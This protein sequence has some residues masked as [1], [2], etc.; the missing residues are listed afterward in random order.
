MVAPVLAAGM[1]AAPIIGG[2]M[3]QQTAREARA[4]AEAQQRKVEEALA[5]V[6]DPN[7]DMSQF[8]PEEYKLVGQYAPQMLPM[9]EERAPQ[10]AQLSGAGQQG[11]QAM[12]GALQHLTNLG[13]T[14]ADA[15]S[16]ALN[17]QA[18]QQAA[19]QN[20]GQQASIL[21]SMQRRG[22]G[23]GSGLGFAA[24][25]SAQQ[26][27]GQQASQAGTQQA[28][29]NYQNRLQALMQA[30]Q[31]GGQ[32]QNM[33]FN[34]QQTNAGIINQFNQ[35]MANAQQQNAMYN[36]G[37]LNEARRT[38]LGAQQNTADQNVAM[39]NQALAQKNQLA[40][41][42]YQNALDKVRVQAGV[43]NQ[44]AQNALAS[45]AQQNQATQGLTQ[46]ISS[47]LMFAGSGNDSKQT[48]DGLYVDPLEQKNY[49]FRNPS[50]RNV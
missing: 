8:S 21:D 38:N 49:N 12:L 31:M 4:A 20:Q 43:S 40:Q 50:S 6:Q 1:I 44:S 34:Q 28:L 48:N 7:F 25:L 42:Q 9:V 23:A 32:A 35:R 24:A 39:R 22:G 47:G 3:Q 13:K 17:A 2:F 11:Q 41:Q 29:A 30:G 45:G 10:L 19:I 36:T 16:Q 46:G 15:Q 26:G 14:G 27:A 18:M 33:D 5:K 37:N